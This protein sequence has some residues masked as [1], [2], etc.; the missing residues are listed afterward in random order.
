MAEAKSGAGMDTEFLQRT[1]GEALSEALAMLVVAQPVDPVEFIGR[2]LLDYIKRREIETQRNE[3]AAEVKP[4]LEIS[5]EQEQIL[6]ET[7]AAEEA[8]IQVMAVAEQEVADAVTKLLCHAD[9][10][11]KVIDFVGERLGATGVQLGRKLVID[12]Q[13]IFEFIA[14]SAGQEHMIGQELRGLQE[15]QEEDEDATEEGV[16]FDLWKKTETPPEPEPVYDEDG[17]L[18]PDEE[19]PELIPPEHVLVENVMRNPRVKFFGIPKLGSYLALP[20]TYDTWLYPEGISEIPPP[21]QEEKDDENDGDDEKDR[22]E[23][24]AEE[25][26]EKEVVA[27]ETSERAKTPD[28]LYDKNV[29]PA[30]LALC[31]NTIGQGRCFS[32][33][34]V[35]WAKT[36][37]S[38]LKAGIEA[39][40][41]Q[42]FKDEAALLASFNGSEA[43]ELLSRFTGDEEAE[44]ATALAGLEEETPEED[45]EIISNATRYRVKIKAIEAVG[46]LMGSMV[47]LSVAP[48]AGVLDVLERALLLIGKRREDL[49]DARGRL[50]WPVTMRVAVGKELVPAILA[51]NPEDPANIPLAA[52]AKEALESIDAEGVRA[53]NLPVSAI[54]EWMSCA[55][56]KVENA[57]AAAAAAKEAAEAAEAAA[58]EEA[59]EAAAAEALAAEQGEDDDAED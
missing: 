52:E 4:L 40:E 9:M 26:G 14:A 50:D 45:K 55:I 41:G 21:G 49:C 37:A 56:T 33:S 58:A 59:A 2:S 57:E 38:R 47:K 36:W 23:E 28:E 54:L 13:E 1:V 24:D 35:E 10:Y 53:A 34:D 32:E 22:D 3:H 19:E 7:R 18:V 46:E 6:A 12:G 15:G 25:D 44:I 30:N 8:A 29:E 39:L 31:L 11:S 48:L 51:F 42:M 27:E 20:I 43:A 16:T 17:E 5:R